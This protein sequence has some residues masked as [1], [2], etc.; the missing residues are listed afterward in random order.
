MRKLKD[1]LWDAVFNVAWAILR[2]LGCTSL[3]AEGWDDRPVLEQG[4]DRDA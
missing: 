4:E 2:R 3:K 1:W